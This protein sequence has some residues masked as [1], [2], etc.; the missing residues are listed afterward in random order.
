MATTVP[1]ALSDTDLPDL[2][3]LASPSIGMPICSHSASTAS[4]WNTRQRPVP[5]LCSG[6]P[7]ASREPSALMETDAPLSS[8]AASPSTSAPR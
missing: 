1:S 4:H 3:F 2:S 8:P 6:A 5:S 7:T